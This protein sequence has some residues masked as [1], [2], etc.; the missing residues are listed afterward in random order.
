MAAIMF[1]QSSLWDL[2]WWGWHLLRLAAYATALTFIVMNS[3]ERQLLALTEKLKQTSQYKSEFMS[4]M[5]HELRT[6]LNSLL[7]LSNCLAGN[8]EG[9]L[10]DKQVEMAKVINRSGTDLLTLVNDILDL[11]RVEAGKLEIQ[12]KDV[13][14]GVI[15]DSL[16]ALFAPVARQK[17][18]EWKIELADDM[19]NSVRTDGQRVEQ[20]LRNLLSN[21]FKFTPNGSVTLSVYRPDVSVGFRHRDFVPG[22]VVA[23]SVADTGIGIPVELQRTVF[24]AF[25]QGDGSISRKFGGT[26]LGLTIS[27]ELTRL[28]GGEIQITGDEGSGT[29]STLYLPLQPVAD[30]GHET[31]QQPDSMTSASQQ[32]DP[33]GSEVTERLLNPF[34]SGFLPDR[35]E[36]LGLPDESGQELRGKKILL[37]DDDARNTFA[38]SSVLQKSGIEIVMAANGIMA[39]DQLDAHPDIELVVMDI[40][41][42]VMDGHTAIR[43]IRAQQSFRELPIIAL[44]AKAMPG[45]QAEC[46][47]SGADDY[48]TKPVD[49]DKL[50]SL[51]RER[52]IDCQSSVPAV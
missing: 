19:P 26:G 9:N 34:D 5:S 42:P 50:L 30:P 8:D 4:N 51:L 12:F 46:L 14:L 29:K 32:I 44:T 13:K 24:E 22:R 36:Q 16:E 43:A 35:Q 18:I 27:R 25:Q 38:L 48:M 47:E 2:S 3:S 6:P 31:Q 21:A 39:L 33:A 7:I 41:M 49:T 28:L 23:I 52:L 45:D 11:S 1:E 15:A 10:T 40:M 37:V 20:V 17:E